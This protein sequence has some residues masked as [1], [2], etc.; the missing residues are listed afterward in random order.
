M[1]LAR[2]PSMTAVSSKPPRRRSSAHCVRIRSRPPSRKS[3]WRST[4]FAGCG[5]SS[6]GTIKLQHD[7]DRVG[8]RR[9]ADASQDP[10]RFGVVPV[11]QDLGEDVGVAARLNL[12]EEAAGDLFAAVFQT[13]G[14]DFAPGRLDDVGKV[15]HDAAQVGIRDVR[16][17]PR[18]LGERA[19]DA[20]PRRDV[21][22]LRAGQAHMSSLNGSIAAALSAAVS[23]ALVMAGTCITWV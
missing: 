9:L 6:S 11:V 10:L 19:C 17:G 5:A 3:I 18:P 4:S 14:G 15:E 20:E 16:D 1:T 7:Q 2:R 21:E 23:S 13:G 8:A 12:V 22:A